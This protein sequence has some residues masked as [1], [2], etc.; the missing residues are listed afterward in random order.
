MQDKENMIRHQCDTR[1]KI[2]CNNYNIHVGRKPKE[3]ACIKCW[4][5]VSGDSGPSTSVLLATNLP[6][7]VV[8]E[9]NQAR[10]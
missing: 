9:H 2:R 10:T 3:Y 4:N 5:P 8:A 7:K 1:I 6:H